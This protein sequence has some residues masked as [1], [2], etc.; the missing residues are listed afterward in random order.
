MLPEVG[1]ADDSRPF[2]M[3]ELCLE[4]G[5]CPPMAEKSFETFLGRQDSQHN[6]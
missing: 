5:L 6:I 4:N 3:A 1:R 2:P